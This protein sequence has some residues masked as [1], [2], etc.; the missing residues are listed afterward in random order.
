MAEGREV[1]WPLTSSCLDADRH[2]L[3]A[4]TCVERQ[5]GLN[6]VGWMHAYITSESESTSLSLR[7]C[8]CGCVS[9]IVTASAVRVELTN[10]MIFWHL[11]DFRVL[12]RQARDR[13]V[14]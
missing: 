11:D 6:L 9:R 3:H 5:V 10:S 13:N 12:P 2:D 1:S 7:M 4:Y 14:K 8:V